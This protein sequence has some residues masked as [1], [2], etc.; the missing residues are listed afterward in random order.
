MKRQLVA[1]YTVDAGADGRGI[2]VVFWFGNY[3]HCRPTPGFG[4]PPK[5]AAEFATQ[6]RDTLTARERLKI[7]IR[8]IDVS[9]PPA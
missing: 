4:S 6:L 8:V 3:E 2:Y 9:R 1:R 7:S 5:S